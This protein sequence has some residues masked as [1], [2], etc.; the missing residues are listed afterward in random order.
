MRQR[1]GRRG[2]GI[3]TGVRGALLALAVLIAA[4][5][6]GPAEPSPPVPEGPSPEEA[7]R[8][9]RR[10]RCHDPPGQKLASFYSVALRRTYWIDMYDDGAG[11]QP[12]EHVPMPHHHATRLELTNA[13]AF[14]D[15]RVRRGTRRARFIIQIRAREIRP[16]SAGRPWFTTYRAH[17]LEACA[18]RSRP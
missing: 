2:A 8:A 3:L 12:I 10:A 17:V 16:A 15:R 6:R 18:L 9:A 13:A 5:W 11:W 14:L 7:A 4:C 1:P